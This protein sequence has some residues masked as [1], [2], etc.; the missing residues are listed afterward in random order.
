MAKKFILDKAPFIRRVDN[1]C[2]TTKQMMMD[3]IIALFPLIL[4]S[5]VKNGLL[6]YLSQFFAFEGKLLAYITP[7][8]TMSI[9]DMLYPLVFVMCGGLFSIIMEGVY[10]YLFKYYFPN[11]YTTPKI[12]FNFKTIVDEVKKSYAIIP[13]LILALILPLNTPIYVLAFGCFIANIVFKMLYGGFGHNVFNPA[14]IAYAII[15]LGYWTIISANDTLQITTGATPLGNLQSINEITYEAVIGPYGSLWSFFLG[16]IPGSIGETSSI[17]IFLGFGYLVIRKT[18]SYIVPVFYVGTVFIITSIIAGINGYGIWYPLFQVLSGG[19][20]FG[21]VFMATEPVTTPTSPNGKVIY[22]IF[23]GIFTLIFRLFGSN[24]EGVAT[25][26][27]FVSLF[28]SFIDRFSARIRNSKTTF[29]GSLGYIFIGIIM[30]ALI[31]YIILGSR[32]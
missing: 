31:V 24:P 9:W 21:A 25:A 16:F 19:L 1:D 22:G 20:L 2:V 27:L 26:I 10:F 17:L 3:V 15:M 8:I 7:N 11:K 30:I 4:F 29:K 18:I 13:G 5:F 12:N 14:L 23:L 28:S 6:P 32:G